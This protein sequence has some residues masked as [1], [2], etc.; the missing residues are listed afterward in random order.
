MAHVGLVT[1]LRDGMNLVAKEYVAA[2]DPDDPGVLVL[3][4]FAGA[5]PRNSTAPF[6]STR[7][8][9]RRWPRRS[10]PP[11]ICPLLNGR[12]GTSACSIISPAND[13]RP[14]GRAIP[15]HARGTPT[16]GENPGRPATTLRRPRLGPH[17]VENHR[18]AVMKKTGS[19][20]LSALI[21]MA[22]SADGGTASQSYSYG[23]H[24]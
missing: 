14:L 8:N 23:R 17:A 19:H 10:N 15:Q 16:A 18:A 21:R 6:S 3:S 1:P 9:S 24:R 11:S 20:S 2:Q 12:N 4:R 7:T 22:I 13:D 5:A